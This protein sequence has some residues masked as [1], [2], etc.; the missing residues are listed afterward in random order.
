MLIFDFSWQLYNYLFTVIPTI[1]LE[2]L[3][4]LES[5]LGSI[6]LNTPEYMV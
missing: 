3:M 6:K 4:A 5:A 1:L 2:K